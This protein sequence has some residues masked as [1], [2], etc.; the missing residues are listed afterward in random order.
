MPESVLGAMIRRGLDRRCLSPISFI[1]LTPNDGGGSQRSRISLAT[2]DLEES[3]FNAPSNIER[4]SVTETSTSSSLASG[5]S[6]GTVAESP[7]KRNSTLWRRASS[8]SIVLKA[9]LSKLFS[10]VII[11]IRPQINFGGQVQGYLGVSG[12]HGTLL[13]WVTNFRCLVTNTWTS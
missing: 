7:V 11:R 2:F 9:V 5:G 6:R 13:L 10:I 8:N 4:R 3:L 1:V 12:Q